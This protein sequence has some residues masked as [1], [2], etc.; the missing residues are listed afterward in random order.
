MQLIPNLL[1]TCA[2]SF[3][4]LRCLPSRFLLL[5]RCRVRFRQTLH[6]LLVYLEVFERA[7]LHAS[8]RSTEELFRLIL[9]R[10]WINSVKNAFGSPLDTKYLGACN[11]ARDYTQG[12]IA[13]LSV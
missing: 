11:Q 8:S 5:V 7:D 9:A 2:T 1:Y 3:F 13:R 6:F 10:C 12:Y 4:P